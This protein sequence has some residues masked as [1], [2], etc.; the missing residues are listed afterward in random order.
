M[1]YNNLTEYNRVVTASSVSVKSSVRRRSRAFSSTAPTLAHL[2]CT[3]GRRRRRWR[4][5]ARAYRPPGRGAGGRAS[6]EGASSARAP[7]HYVTQHAQDGAQNNMCSVR[8]LAL[9]LSHGSD[10][11]VPPKKNHENLKVL[12]VSMIMVRTR[13]ST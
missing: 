4:R 10:I 11:S 1:K 3:S 2:G 12:F 6:A 13:V 9:E 8:R 7:S 5:A